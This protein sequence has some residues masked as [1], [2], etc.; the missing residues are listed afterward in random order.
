M[1]DTLFVKQESGAAT[2][3]TVTYDDTGWDTLPL[4]TPLA[5]KDGEL[6]YKGHNHNNEYK[7]IKEKR[8]SR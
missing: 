3:A 5:Y 4:C 7:R 1:K 6:I 8:Y 2:F